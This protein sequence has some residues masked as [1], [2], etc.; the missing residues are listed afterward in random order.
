MV[1]RKLALPALMSGV[2]LFSGCV[3]Q[4]PK[5]V[6]VLASVPAPGFH[7]ELAE[8][9]KFIAANL[10]QQILE[11][12]LTAAHLIP[13]DL[14][15][16]EHSAE[17][18]IA[19]KNLQKNLV[20]ALAAAKPSAKFEA[21]STR[22]I[23]QARW[24]VVSSYAS[25]KSTEVGKSGKWLRL[26]VAIADV[27]SGAIRA[28]VTTHVD[29]DKFDSAPTLFYR[30]APMY[31]TDASHQDRNSVL[32][33][34]GRP[35][36]DSLRV[37]ATLTEALEAFDAER[38]AEAEQ[39]FQ[40]VLKLA[41]DHTGAL[42][43]LYQVLWM[44][45]KKAEAESVFTRLAGVSVDAGKLSVKLLFK[46]GS[47]DFVEEGD[48]AQQYLVWLRSMARTVKQRGVCLNVNGH[49]SA[50][51]SDD[52]NE[53]L[54]LSR[55]NRIVVRMGQAVPFTK[56]VLVAQGK[57]TLEMIV[58]TGTNDASDSIDRRVEFVVRAC[59]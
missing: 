41:P 6:E 5:P 2:L 55:A 45:G 1:L 21:L 24:V 8:A 11:G 23:Q 30:N 19:S 51:G 29:S 58:G 14:F 35:L 46:L 26:K 7:S 28:Q 16:N 57:G 31:L 22:N 32:S 56:G 36:G 39:G 42:S 17:E 27:K 43:G 25:V 40:S 50:S 52:Y 49:A 20:A 47:T 33:G 54:S 9:V 38:W 13:V 48:L 10:P 18:A 34:Q 59:Q 44:A 3:T 53:R 12:E 15:F 37:R 4:P